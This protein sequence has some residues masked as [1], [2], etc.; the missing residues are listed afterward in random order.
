MEG[1]DRYEP[2]PEISELPRWLWRKMGR[3]LRIAIVATA[4]AGLAAAA[5]AMPAILESKDERAALERKE[6]AALTAERIKELQAEQ[7][8][9]FGRSEATAPAAAG[10]RERLA[11]RARMLDELSA[12]ILADARKRFRAGKLDGP[13][14][15]AECAAFPRTVDGKGAESDLSRRRGGY[16]C[17]AVTAEFER[18]DASVGGEL[19]HPF[20]ARID[21]KSGRYAYCKISGRADL[22]RD[23]AVT[24]PRA[25]GG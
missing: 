14:L 7:R 9:H 20:R 1:P 6:R 18:S 10:P 16:Y 25:C 11:A 12:S 22:P 2:L 19:G 13:I 5:A 8:P 21:F 24:T 15:R 23:P 4:V 17:V 3:G